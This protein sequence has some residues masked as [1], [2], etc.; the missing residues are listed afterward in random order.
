MLASRAIAFALSLL[1]CA[2]VL[3]TSHDGFTDRG[4]DAQQP[5]VYEYVL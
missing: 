4:K 5:I 1:F 3:A 2:E